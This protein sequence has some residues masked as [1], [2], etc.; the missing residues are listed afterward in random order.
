MTTLALWTKTSTYASADLLGVPVWRR[1]L[2]AASSLGV[3]RVVWISPQAP[4]G[5]QFCHPGGLGRLRGPVLLMPAE[6]PL[7]TGASLRRLAKR[8]RN[9]GARTLAGSGVVY[10][11]SAEALGALG[12]SLN[13]LSHRLDATPVFPDHDEEILRV[14][15]AGTFAKAVSILR[16]RKVTALMD[17]GVVIGDPTGVLVDPEVVVSRGAVLHPF[18]VLE[19]NTRI[20]PKCVVSSFSHIVDSSIGAGTVVLDHSFIRSSRIGRGVSIGPFAHLRPDSHVSDHA[21]VGNFVEL[22]NTR[23]GEGAKAPH[24]SYLGDA[25]VGRGSNIGAGTITCNYDGVQKHRTV[26]GDGAFIGSDVQ[27]VAPVRV[28]KGAYVAAGSCIV[29]DV[30]AY[31]LA[32]ARTRQL[33]KRGWARKRKKSGLKKTKG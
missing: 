13:G 27:L 4:P 16:R 24:L 30:P 7:L 17:K 2:Q 23:L 33:V 25:T 1:T 29:E 31:A 12:P 5:I 3:G 28:G 19:G 10:A 15:D 9:G 21:R 8:R 18:V 22:K 6:L 20:G 14:S 11:P 26:V 32:L